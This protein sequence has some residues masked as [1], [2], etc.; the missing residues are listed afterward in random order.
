MLV[1]LK[2][3]AP[4]DLGY[5]YL[6]FIIQYDSQVFDNLEYTQ[7]SIY[8]EGNYTAGNE[9]DNLFQF[10]FQSP[11][12]GSIYLGKTQVCAALIF[13]LKRAAGSRRFRQ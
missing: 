4:N 3:F 2:D 7:H 5:S 1:H 12:D 9:V 8:T 10:N 13:R 6:N 11:V